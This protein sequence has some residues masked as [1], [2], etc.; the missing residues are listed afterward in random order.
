MAELQPRIDELESAV[1]EAR[2]ELAR[3]KVTLQKLTKE[4]NEAAER[5]VQLRTAKSDSEVQK[6]QLAAQLTKVRGEPDK[7]KKQAD[8][9]A[10][11][12]SNQQVE[13]DKL[14]DALQLLEAELANQVCP[15]LHHL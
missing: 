10:T 15:R 12:V 1:E 2:Q 3:H 8:M 13:V 4:R 6:T 11:A 9:V 5:G 7:M 14:T